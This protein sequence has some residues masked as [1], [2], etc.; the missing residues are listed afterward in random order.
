MAVD[1][2]FLVSMP[3]EEK[4]PAQGNRKTCRELTELVSSISKLPL[5]AKFKRTL[6]IIEV[7]AAEKPQTPQDPQATIYRTSSSFCRM[8]SG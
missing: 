5:A 7:Q 3:G 4:H 8:A 1:P 6:L 2:F